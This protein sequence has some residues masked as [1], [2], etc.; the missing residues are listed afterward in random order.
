VNDE[1]GVGLA[2]AIRSLRAEL[3]LSMQEAK[4]EEIRFR[5]GPVELEFLLEV[6]QEAGAEGGVRF[7]VVSLGAK[8]SVAR[9][10]THRIKLSLVP[11]TAEGKDVS[12]VDEVA[13]KPK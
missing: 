12:V 1:A 6:T 7:Y 3:S 10:A 2:E 5:V 11:A 9:T 4:G 13:E 8:G